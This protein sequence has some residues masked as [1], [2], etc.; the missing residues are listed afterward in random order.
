MD[1][2]LQ[3]R[4]FKKHATRQFEDAKGRD[5]PTAHSNKPIDP[6]LEALSD[7]TSTSERSSPSRDPE[8]YEDTRDLEKGESADEALDDD[9]PA[10]VD[11]LPHSLM[12]RATT[13]NSFGTALGNTLTGIDVRDRTTHEGQSG[14]VFVVGYHGDEDSLNPHN[15]STFVRIR[16][17]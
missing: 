12:R 16:A 6:R 4:R 7:P 9:R 11:D 8:K 17:T 3:Y 2:F 5:L 14:K 10:A 1:S 15:W 13:R